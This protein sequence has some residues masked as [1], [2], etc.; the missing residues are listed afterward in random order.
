MGKGSQEKL[1]DQVIELKLTSKSPVRQ[2]KKCDL[3]EKAEKAKIKKTIEKGIKRIQQFNYLRFASRLNAVAASHLCSQRKLQGYQK[4]KASI[5]KSLQKALS[6]LL[7]NMEVQAS[8]VESS[9]AGTSSLSTPEGELVSLIQQ[10]GE[11]EGGKGRL[12]LG[13]RSLQKPL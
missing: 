3:D 2:A 11:D 7:T 8:C 9:T 6:K 13:L 1:M 5:V 4:P 10:V 12:P